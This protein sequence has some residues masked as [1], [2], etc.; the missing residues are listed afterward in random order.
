MCSGSSREKRHGPP[1]LKA[2]LLIDGNQADGVDFGIGGRF[3]FLDAGGPASEWRSEV[4]IGWIDRVSSEYYWRF[5]GTKLFF[6]PQVSWEH[7]HLPVYDGTTRVTNFDRS[8]LTLS[9]DLVMRSGDSRSCAWGTGSDVSIRGRSPIRPTSRNSRA[10]PRRFGR[11]GPTTGRTARSYPTRGFRARLEASWYLDY[12]DINRNFPLAVGQ[13]S[14][15]T[16]S[17]ANTS[18]ISG[19][20]GHRRSRAFTGHLLR[21]WGALQAQRPGPGT[22]ARRT[23]LLRGGVTPAVSPDPGALP[24]HAGVGGGQ[25]VEI[26]RV[27]TAACLRRR[28]RSD[29][30]HA[31]RA[32]LPRGSRGEH[33]EAKALFRIGRYF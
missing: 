13:V 26:P 7:R 31:A 15:R 33:G 32:D 27:D 10:A 5:K 12:P 21:S 14:W 1:F 28:F 25:R 2:G 20:R 9:G 22:A 18:F 19:R 6:A 16:P 11:D 8:T 17:E 24:C 29:W 3:I 30:R 4:D 23:L